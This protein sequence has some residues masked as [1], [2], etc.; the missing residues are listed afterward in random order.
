MV[1]IQNMIPIEQKQNSVSK[2]ANNKGGTNSDKS[3]L[4]FAKALNV[5][6][7][8]NGTDVDSKVKSDDTMQFMAAMAGMVV[9]IVVKLALVDQV[10]GNTADTLGETTSAPQALLTNAVPVVPQALLTNA[11]PVVPQAL[12]TNAVPVVPQA[13]LTNAVPVVPQTLLSNA[14]SVIPQ[15]LLSNAVPVIPQADVVPEDSGKVGLTVDMNTPQNQLATLL[16]KMTTVD[17]QVNSKELGEFP[18]LQ[19]QTQLQNKSI[20]GQVP[21]T[22]VAKK[23][24]DILTNNLIVPN[25]AP[26]VVSIGNPAILAKNGSKQPNDKKIVASQVNVEA[27]EIGD[28]VGV[29][30]AVAVKS[31]LAPQAIVTAVDGKSNENIS[32]LLDGKEQANLEILLPN[33]TAKNTDVFA[34]MLNQ[35]GVKIENPSMVE[36]KYV[37]PQPVSDAYNITSQIIDQARLVAGTKNTEMIIQL[38]PEHLGELTFKV[39]VENGIVS[40]SF[41]SNNPEVR[42]MIESSLYQLKQEL[43]SQGLKIDNVGVY[44]GLGHFFSNGQQSG[45]Q[46]QQ[47]VIKVQNKKQ[48]EDFLDVLET[49]D[50][51]SKVLNAAGVDYRV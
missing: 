12:L 1:A 20:S 8:K 11:V 15:A 21:I 46:Q 47:P 23:N 50:S 3:T 29:V 27:T 14:V 35:Q 7:D 40:A 36:V 33:Q 28:R 17:L 44:A 26:T 51:A 42:S 37:T 49:T 16:E 39:S 34:S 48:E 32:M 4:G 43:S 30:G 24:T 45:S 19:A 13:L 9:P 18:E 38:K 2:N 31:I 25:M 41:H 10:V 6:T 22:E 5:E